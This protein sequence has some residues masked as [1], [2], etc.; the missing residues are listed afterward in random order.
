MH[1]ISLSA[2]NV[3]RLKA[4]SIKPK[5]NLVQI[6]GKNASGKTSVL[7]A[8]M[9][10]LAGK[11]AIDSDPIRHGATSAR[12]KVDMGELIVTRVITDGGSELR[13]EAADGSQVRSPQKVLDEM[14]GALTF[15]PLEFTRLKPREQFEKLRAIVP[16]D[17]DLDALDKANKADYEARAEY[18][19]NIKSM[20]SA[21]DSFPEFDKDLPKEKVSAAELSAKISEAHAHNERV[22]KLK[23]LHARREGKLKEI[24]EDIERLEAKL[25]ELRT[26]RQKVIEY[27]LEQPPEPIDPSPLVAQ[28]DD[29]ARLNGLI[30]KREEQK[31]VSESLKEAEAAYADYTKSME[32]RERQKRE[33]V[34]KAKM[35][36]P[37][38]G[39]GDGVVMFKDVPLDQAS[40]AEQLRVSVAIAMAANPKLR[41]LRIM[42]GSLLDEDSLGMIAQMAADQDYQVW[43]ECV[44]SSGKVGI[45]IEDGQ[46][47]GD[48][49]SVVPQAPALAPVKAPEPEPVAI[50]PLPA[51]PKPV[52]DDEE[53]PF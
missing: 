36:V 30:A 28:L 6:T 49:Q 1:I 43:I 45:V 51:A 53:I 25:A 44:D 4:V 19:R 8:I 42:E 16:L 27:T 18:G 3:K 46:V 15:D 23:D 20:K 26:E 14:L 13:V 37:G 33:A 40:T 7:D 41:V 35:P 2:E 50:A 5:G 10:A 39:F 32:E 47:K 29:I 22:N 9:W 52:S 21:L 17:V 11:N 38:L 31:L 24:D 34:E 12:I 48:F